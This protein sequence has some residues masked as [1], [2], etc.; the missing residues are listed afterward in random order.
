MLNI[1]YQFQHWDRLYFETFWIEWVENGC[2]E[3]QWKDGSQVVNRDYSL[4]VFDENNKE[5]FVNDIIKESTSWETKFYQIKYEEA[6]FYA[7]EIKWLDF[8]WNVNYWW[9]WSMS[10]FRKERGYWNKNTI[11][12]DV[13]VLWSI[14]EVYDNNLKLS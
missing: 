13:Y 11:L 3:Y 9:E 7:I 1:R 8:D 10:K 2:V 14:Y 4:E 12:K 5:L 6:T